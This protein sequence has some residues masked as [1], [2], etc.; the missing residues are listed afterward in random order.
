[1]P[2]KFKYKACTVV[3]IIEFKEKLT[4]FNGKRVKYF[5][6]QVNE[7]IYAVYLYNI[8]VSEIPKYYYYLLKMTPTT[9]RLTTSNRSQ[10]STPLQ[11]ATL[12][13]NQ[14]RHPRLDTLKRVDALTPR[15]HPAA[16]ESLAARRALS[17][18]RSRVINK[19]CCPG[20]HRHR[21]IIS[22]CEA[23]ACI[24]LRALR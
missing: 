14:Q 6:R 4:P 2:W 23:R 12:D 24:R 15:A 11:T 16:R 21:L 19:P 1:M 7:I 9:I 3:S 22:L 20:F 18:P 5:A 17:P 10:F 13:N 8:S